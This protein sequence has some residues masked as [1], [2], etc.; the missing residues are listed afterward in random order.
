MSFYGSSTF[1]T[2]FFCL[3]VALIAIAACFSYGGELNIG[4]G[5]TLYLYS[6]SSQCSVENS[7]GNEIIPRAWLKGEAVTV[8]DEKEVENFLNNI[9][10]KEVFSESG[11]LFDC[12]YY[13]SPKIRYAASVNGKRV[14]LHV[15]K[16]DGI[17][18][19]GTPVIFGDF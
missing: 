15:S 17:V 14:N 10:A 13:Y 4:T 12:V 7:Y 6:S 11:E 18:K 16:R 9:K 3:F 5:K 1:K 8:C 19:I 2:V